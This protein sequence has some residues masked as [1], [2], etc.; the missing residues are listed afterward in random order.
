MDLRDSTFDW[1]LHFYYLAIISDY[2][3]SKVNIN[4]LLYN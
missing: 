4:L 1:R 3:K 2:L